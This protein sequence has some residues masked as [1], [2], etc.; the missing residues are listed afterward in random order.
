MTW[1]QELMKRVRIEIPILVV[2]KIFL[3]LLAALMLIPVQLREHYFR[4][5]QEQAIIVSQTRT[6]IIQDAI[7]HLRE[8]FTDFLILMK[9]A[10]KLSLN[11]IQDT[12]QRMR[13][14]QLKMRIALYTINAF[15]VELKKKSDSFI[16]TVDNTMTAFSNALE[17]RGTSDS[18]SKW[19]DVEQAQDGLLKMYPSITDAVGEALSSALLSDIQRQQK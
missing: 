7:G 13:L 18:E 3:V 15:N 1:Q 16:K 11:E 6:K 10:R 9:S 19:Q 14:A 17:D 2:D 12:Q 5:K 8:S 4:I